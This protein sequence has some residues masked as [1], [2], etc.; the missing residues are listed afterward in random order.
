[1][2][3]NIVFQYKPLGSAKPDLVSQ[4]EELIFAKAEAPFMPNVGDSVTYTIDGEQ[5]S[6]IVLSRHFI[7]DKDACTIHMIVGDLEANELVSRLRR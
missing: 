2:I 5:V 7:Y 3:Y 1:M 6:R 4:D